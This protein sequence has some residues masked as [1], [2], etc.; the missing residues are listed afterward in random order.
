MIE[1]ILDAVG[2]GTVGKQRGPAFADISQDSFL[3]DN[4]QVRILLARK[5]GR[6]QIFSGGAGAYGIAIFFTKLYK[7]TSD[8]IFDLFRN[9]DSFND[10]ADFGADFTN[11]FPVVR[12]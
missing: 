5:G 11:T 6:R 12:F 4:V 10:L 7:M 2:H 8:L 1:S 3:S 9:S